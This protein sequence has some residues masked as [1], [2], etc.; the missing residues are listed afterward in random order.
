MAGAIA[1]GAMAMGCGAGG[2]DVPIGATAAGS[3]GGTSAS[4]SHG[5]G[6][7]GGAGASGSGGQDAGGAPYPVVLAHGFFGFEEFAG[8]DF[9]NYFW[10]TKAHLAEH[11]EEVHTPAVDPFNSSEVRGAQLVERIEEI[12]AVTGHDK[13]NLVGHSQGGLD[14]RVVAHDRPD[15]V[16]SVTTFATPHYGTPIADIAMELIEDENLQELLDWLVQVVGM[17][18]WDEVGDQTSLAAPLY[19]FSQEGIA[20]FNATYTDAP[21]VLYQSFTGRSG[22]HLGGPDCEPELEVP[23]VTKHAGDKDRIDPLLDLTE[24]I[25]DG[26]FEGDVP[27]DGL[28]RARDAR[29]GWFLGC[30]PA[31]HLD[32]IGHLFGDAPGP[33]NA[34]DHKAFYLS[35][36]QHLRAQ[37]Y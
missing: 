12:L 30:V 11:G 16:A 10:E 22:D 1:F 27:N 23:F 37:G 34:W 24:R 3:G 17:P 8:V 18:L 29:W 5:A 28:V 26:D 35:V 31:D 15:L 6:G 14:A 32:E 21:T 7:A 9:V 13:V 25:L 19:L 20:A 33:E 2:E 36:V 4:S